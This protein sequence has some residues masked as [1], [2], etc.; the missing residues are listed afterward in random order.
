MEK[1]QITLRD[2]FDG[3]KIFQIPNY[4]R[5][6][7]WE[8]KQLEEFM[9]DFENQM[10]GKAYFFG[11]ILFRTAPK[12]DRFE[13]IEIVD[14]QQRITTLMMY[15]KLLLDRLKETDQDIELDLNTYVRY[16]GRY[17]LRVLQAD[18]VFFENYILAGND[19][20]NY[21]TTPSQRRLWSARR[22]LLQRVN[23]YSPEKV[24]EILTII[25]NTQVLTYS[26]ED[27]AEATLIFEVTNDRGKRL[28]NLEKTKSFL[29]HKTYLASSDPEADLERI[30]D[31]FVEIYRDFEAIQ[32]LGIG[33][34]SILQY[35]FIACESWASNNQEKQY[36]Q[37]VDRIK[38][39][40]N[41]RFAK[42]HTSTME[43]I[44]RYTREL[45]E[46][47]AVMKIL[48]LEPGTYGLQDLTALG[49]QA[50]F[51]PL[52]IKT[53]KLDTAQNKP[54][55]K[56]V[57]RLAEIISF[58]VWGVRRRRSDTGRDTLYALARDFNG[59]YKALINRLKQFIQ[60]YAN[61]NEFSNRLRDPAL[62][63]N[64]AGSDQRY[65]FWKYE[66][67][68]RSTERP[69]ASEMPYEEFAPQDHRLRLSIE[70]IAP[71]NPDKSRVV[72][73]QSIL[74]GLTKEFSEKFLHS[75]GNLTIDP[76]SANS[77]K[78]NQDFTSK[79]NTHFRR[80]PFKTQ[81]ELVDFLNPATG[82]WDEE[83]IKKRA[84]KI[85]SFARDY[86]NPTPI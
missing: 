32:E 49:R 79:D 33:E 43:F 62:Y 29:M 34:D 11:T 8:K 35:H 45:R 86:W 22:I 23:G 84:A 19:G 64:L 14:G 7:A 41:G 52:L 67:H 81:N 9:T 66:N 42:D 5:A 44:K 68:L 18:N 63:E 26:V 65:L 27:N 21:I 85:L 36:V 10:P 12:Q 40:V 80:A 1:G 37:Y 55:F 2:L 13:M 54:N 73:D 25:E 76:L 30:Q 57:V 74:P 3:T 38:A 51:F 78:S 83:S 39:A 56:R 48:Q 50:V 15:I 53:F 71:Q 17:K 28:T 24:R 47:Y 60:D 82:Q 58:R 70:H 77:S 20:S 69:I 59:D 75:L 31:N 46:S 6:Y 72:T 4:Q 61:D 16:S